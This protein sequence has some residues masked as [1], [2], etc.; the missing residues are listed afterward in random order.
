MKDD[1]IVITGANRGIGYEIARKLALSGRPIVMGCRDLT[2]SEPARQRIAAES[3]NKRVELITLDLSS[4]ESIASFVAALEKRGL[5]IG[6]LV[7]NAGILCDR[8]KTN[9]EGYE[10]GLA[11]NYLGPAR[12]SLL[13]LPLMSKDGARIINTSSCAYRIGRIRGDFFRRKEGNFHPIGS[14]SDEK[15]ALI[16]F[17]LEL[18]KRLGPRAIAVN[19]ID[20]GIVN[21]D[22]IT[23]NKWFDPLTDH[24]F[25]PLIA[26]EE[27]GAR[28]S[29]LLASLDDSRKLPA[30]W[31]VK[32]RERRLPGW[33]IRHPLRQWL[34]ETTNA[35]CGPSI[36]VA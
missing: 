30:S 29:I 31:L 33:I 8:F 23:M 20:P 36:E 15:L 25:R 17:S 12:L 35:L 2:K 16:L 10:L 4:F 6:A 34:W 3:G 1:A 14:Y 28:T 22:I 27:E 13:A 11:V 21:T 7:N 24:F 19:A 5:R 18:A 32:G 26:T 9:S